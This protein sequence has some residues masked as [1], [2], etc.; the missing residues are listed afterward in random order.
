MCLFRQWLRICSVLILAS[1]IS[2]RIHYHCFRFFISTTARTKKTK[3]SFDEKQKVNETYRLVASLIGDDSV[4]RT[5][6]AGVE[7]S[8]MPVDEVILITIIYSLFFIYNFIEVSPYFLFT[9][10]VERMTSA[11]LTH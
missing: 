10:V 5:S 6:M 7:M 11:S 4:A 8:K 1:L 2:I 3:E 9:K